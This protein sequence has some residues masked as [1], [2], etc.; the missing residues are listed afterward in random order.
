MT[1]DANEWDGITDEV[2]CASRDIPVQWSN[3]KDIGWVR[4]RKLLPVIF[5]QFS[6]N[7]ARTS[8]EGTPQPATNLQPMAKTA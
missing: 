7:A 2:W 5:V 1:T 6:R 4:L 8:S 3:R